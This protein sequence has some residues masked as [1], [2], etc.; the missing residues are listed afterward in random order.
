MG[1][2]T[3]AHDPV[4]IDIETVPTEAALAI[5]YPE[6]DR[7]PPA[8]YKSDEAIERWRT[9]DRL[10]WVD[11]SIK[12]YS[13]NPRLG[14]VLCVGTSLGASYATIEREEARALAFFWDSVFHTTGR[15]VTWNG[16]WDLR[17]LVL[18]SAIL[19]VQPSLSPMKIREWFRRYTVSPHFD[20][21]AVLLNWDV[22]VAGEG[23]D[24]WGAAL[25]VGHKAEGLDG[26][27]V[28]PLFLEGE[29][30]AIERYC[31]ADVELTKGI[32]HVLA[33][34]FGSA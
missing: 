11:A 14:R 34:V 21:K 26:G 31:M 23:L 24:E 12:Q 5:P 33:P 17:F 4:V 7:T 30:E 10:A 6:A 8:N 1:V 22:R 28:W 15:V 9:N 25:R 2:S 16:A 29:H 18:R 3:N 20:C 19:G 13:T 32:Y 27:Q